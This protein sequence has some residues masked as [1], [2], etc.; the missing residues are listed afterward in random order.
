MRD[1]ALVAFKRIFL[2]VFLTAN[3]IQRKKM[4]ILQ[5]FTFI[6]KFLMLFQIRKL[7]RNLLFMLTIWSYSFENFQIRS[8]NCMFKSKLANGIC[9]ES[10]KKQI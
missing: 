2:G 9:N 10:Q 6:R 7:S 5:F 4:M 8:G 3:L 1:V